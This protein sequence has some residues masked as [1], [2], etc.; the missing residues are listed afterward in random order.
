[1]R[2]SRILSSRGRLRRRIGAPLA[3]AAVL[4]VTTLLVRAIAQAAAPPPVAPL[5]AGPV[6]AP[7][8]LRGRV[9]DPAG[10]PLAGAAIEILDF[11]EP[12]AHART[13]SASDGRFT[14]RAL[15]RRSVLLRVSHDS[16]YT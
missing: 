14:F 7:I 4:L 5:A 15:A 3:N 10:R 6:D 1:M 9:V 8:D 16:H 12:G 11:A 2:T 13:F